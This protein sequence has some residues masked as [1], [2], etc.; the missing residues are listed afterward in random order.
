MIT[1][2][3]KIDCMDLWAAPELKSASLP[4]T[5]SPLHHMMSAIPLEGE[6]RAPLHHIILLSNNRHTYIRSDSH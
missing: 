3:V 4:T 6:T 2:I 1:R 5:H